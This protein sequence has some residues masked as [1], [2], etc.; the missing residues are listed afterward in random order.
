MARGEYRQS[1]GREGDSGS[2]VD[3]H[4]RLRGDA[5]APGGIRFAESWRKQI[6]QAEEGGLWSSGP[7][8]RARVE[9]WIAPV[10]SL[11]RRIPPHEVLSSEEVMAFSQIRAASARDGRIAGRMLLRIALSHA[12]RGRIAPQDWRLR[13]SPEGKLEITGDLPRLHFSVAHTERLAVIATSAQLPV[14]ID[15]ESIEQTVE[16]NVARD[17]CC[18]GEQAVL[19]K[20]PPT[21]STREFVRLWT[22]KEAYAKLTGRAAAI[23]FSLLGFSL[24]S[25]C[26]THG[27]AEQELQ[28]YFETLFVANGN[29]L[30]HVS[31]AIGAPRPFAL[32]AELQVMTLVGDAEWPAVHVPCIPAVVETP[33]AGRTLS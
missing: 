5:G 22:L 26:L 28:T 30:S 20:L 4:E 8:E 9:V 33:L 25:L 6:V 23:D 24:D 21:Q 11:V 18:P 17:F 13:T 29:G 15:A 27:P 16:D 1:A 19:E 10:A 14:G 2:R 7:R 3:G 12:T 32:C 31:V